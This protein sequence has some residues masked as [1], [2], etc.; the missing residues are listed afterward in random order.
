MRAERDEKGWAAGF[1][2]YAIPKGYFSQNLVSQFF[3][4]Q[5]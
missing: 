2:Q 4:S 3:S 5:I 1:S